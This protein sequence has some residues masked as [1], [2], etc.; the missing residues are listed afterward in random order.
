MRKGTSTIFLNGK[1]IPIIE[2]DPVIKDPLRT[3]VDLFL[4]ETISSWIF[5]KNLP[6]FVNFYLQKGA[7]GDYTNH[8]QFQ[9]KLSLKK[10]GYH[11]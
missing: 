4:S 10:R 3:V 5:M 2:I 6:L 1:K 9:L 7:D 8:E 11:G